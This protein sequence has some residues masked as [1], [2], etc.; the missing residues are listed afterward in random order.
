[1]PQNMNPCYIKRSNRVIQK[2]Q[3]FKQVNSR[4]F[5][6]I[7]NSLKQ[8]NVKFTLHN[9]PDAKI[10]KRKNP[11]ATKCDNLRYIQKR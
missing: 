4:R 1:M 11:N 3:K 10:K 9:L 6:D 7:Q 5:Y 8:V 2:N